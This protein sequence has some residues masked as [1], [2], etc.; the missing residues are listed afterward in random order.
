MPSNLSVETQTQ[1]E[2]GLM[3]SCC[4][5]AHVL[6][7][8]AC[9]C[10]LCVCLS[11]CVCVFTCDRGYSLARNELMR[12]GPAEGLVSGSQIQG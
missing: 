3:C 1:K 7:M 6:C 9:H 8:P 5:C 11:I 12:V 4:G 2:G 10:L